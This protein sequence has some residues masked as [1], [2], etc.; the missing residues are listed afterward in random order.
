MLQRIASLFFFLFFFF[1]VPRLIVA[2]RFVRVLLFI[3]IVTGKDQLERATRRM[4]SIMLYG[5]KLF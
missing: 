3:R 2:A 4:V 5:T 1:P